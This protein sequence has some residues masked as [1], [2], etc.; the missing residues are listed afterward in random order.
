MLPFALYGYRTSV[1]TSTRQHLSLWYM[2]WK[3]YSLFEVEIPS[4]RLLMETQLEE[5]DW[6]QAI[7]EQLN[8]IEEKRL[9]VVCHGQ[10]Y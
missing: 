2:E 3:Q 4:L 9:T 10:L 5:A 8:L 6:V 7:L 1:L